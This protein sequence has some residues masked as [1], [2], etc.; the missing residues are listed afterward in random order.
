MVHNKA[1]YASHKSAAY[2]WQVTRQ[3]A[4]SHSSAELVGTKGLHTSLDMVGSID[5]EVLQQASKPSNLVSMRHQ[6]TTSKP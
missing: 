6:Q 4:Y 2:S 3:A 1:F 5:E